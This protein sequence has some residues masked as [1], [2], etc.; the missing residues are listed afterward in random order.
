MNSGEKY[1]R[2]TTIREVPERKSGHIQWLCICDCGKE[3]ITAKSKLL[4]GHT[5]SCGCYQR[6]RTSEVT[7]SQM[8]GKR[9]GRLV[10]IDETGT[11]PNGVKLWNCICDCGKEKVIRGADLRCGKTT[12]CGC[13]AT[14]KRTKHGGHKEKLYHVY[15]A[16]KDRC[17]NTNNEYYRDYGGRGITV[18]DEWMN[19][20]AAFREWS[21]NNG[22][23]DGLSIDRIN[24]D[25]DY[26]PSNCR[27]VTMRE[28]S[29]NKRTN[30][31]L[32]INGENK[33]LA[34]WSDDY[35]ISRRTVYGRYDRGI[36]GKELFQKTGDGK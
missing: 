23:K 25:G 31:H 18:C 33:V 15:I 10:V 28:Q 13:V 1:G 14:E 36:R 2:L 3:V 22:Y 21:F 4:N 16:M 9:F 27:W 6:D 26:E 29:R 5:K 12:S 32:E 19:D 35:G 30:I 8:A 34:D 17:R 20:Y 24:V 11:A 7:V